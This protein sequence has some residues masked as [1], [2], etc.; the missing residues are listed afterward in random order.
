[1]HTHTR[2]HT[3]KLACIQRQKLNGWAL[4]ASPLPSLSPS[5]AFCLSG[6]ALN[7]KTTQ[8]TS[9]RMWLEA[10]GDGCRGRARAVREASYSGCGVACN[11]IWLCCARR[12]MP[13]ARHA[14]ASSRLF[15][16]L[17]AAIFCLLFPSI[18]ASTNSPPSPCSSLQQHLH[19]PPWP[20]FPCVACYFRLFG[21][22]VVFALSAHL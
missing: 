7:C 4:P 9:Y 13:G 20:T 14:V 16:V 22:L 10:V 18:Q 15:C 19:C 6:C 12:P 11:P 1:M 8:R 3:H 17:D 21:F 5:T 2:T